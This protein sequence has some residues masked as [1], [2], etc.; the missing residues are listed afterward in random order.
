MLAASA[1]LT[2]GL[3]ASIAT[4]GSKTAQVSGPSAAVQLADLESPIEWWYRVCSDEGFDGMPVLRVRA[5]LDDVAGSRVAVPVSLRTELREDAVSE[6][7][8][9]GRPGV[10]L[11][12]ASVQITSAPKL[13]GCTG[14]FVLKLG[15]TAGERSAGL[16]I[17]SVSAEARVYDATPDA[18]WIEAR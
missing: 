7:L 11:E 16:A 1:V 6:A 4:S 12:R 17:V 15:P 5:E 14:W 3:V 2:A 10:R 8:V 18:V 9:P 13:G